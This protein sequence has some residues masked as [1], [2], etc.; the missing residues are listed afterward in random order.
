MQVYEPQEDSFLLEKYVRQ[1][2]KGFCDLDSKKTTVQ[3]AAQFHGVLI[4]LAERY[5]IS[6]VWIEEPFMMFAKG[7]KNPTKP[8]MQHSGV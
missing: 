7:F 5:H 4:D 8:W 2:A 1:Y 6:S 3:K